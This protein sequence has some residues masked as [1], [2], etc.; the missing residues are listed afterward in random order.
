MSRQQLN[1]K[2]SVKRK[3]T[4]SP[5]RQILRETVISD[6]IRLINV[7]KNKHLSSQQQNETRKFGWKK[8]S[9]M[10]PVIRKVIG[11]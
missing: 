7:C 4:K 6:R 1:T 9:A 3:N 10:P 2:V 8:T 5:P 11:R